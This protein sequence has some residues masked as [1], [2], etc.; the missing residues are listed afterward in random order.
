MAICIL[1]CIYIYIYIIHWSE[2]ACPRERGCLDFHPLS[3]VDGKSQYIY[4][5]IYIYMYIY[6]YIYR[7]RERERDNSRDQSTYDSSRLSIDISGNR[8]EKQPQGGPKEG[9]SNRNRHSNRNSNKG[10]P[11]IAA[12]V[13][14]PGNCNSYCKLG[15]VNEAR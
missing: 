6:I 8:G 5:Y 15:F 7:E 11:A 10:L 3:P 9:N 12:V 4:I 1:V 13:Q 14:R 2:P